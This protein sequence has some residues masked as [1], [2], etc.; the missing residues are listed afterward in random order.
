MARAAS[1]ASPV[2]AGAAPVRAGAA[3]VG[4]RAS[5]RW[6]GGPV[7]RWAGGPVGRWAGGPVGRW[8]AVRPRAHRRGRADPG[9]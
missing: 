6:A 5:G 2:R 3:P 1:A 9:R 8:A 4:W 7:G